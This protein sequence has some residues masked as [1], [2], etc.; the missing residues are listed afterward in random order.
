MRLITIPFSHFCEKARW[1]L[2]R[3]GL[4]FTEE[5]H[6]PMLHWR[7][8]APFGRR[9][10]PLLVTDE[11]VVP[12]S[13]DILRFVDRRL[14]DPKRLY[15]A[16]C[17]AE[18]AA[19][20][21]GFDLGLGPH[22][23][24]LGYYYALPD[25]SSVLKMAAE[26]VPRWE[27]ALLRAS[28]PLARAAMKRGMRIDDEGAA[29]SRA[30]VEKTFAE[31]DARLGDGRR[32]LAGDVLTAADIT[33]AALASPLL[34]PPEHPYAYAFAKATVPAPMSALRSQLQASPAGQLALRVYRDHRRN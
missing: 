28:F 7:A 18:V 16:D 17:E 11:G 19:L 29:R 22:A 5:G 15:P 1:A 13:T 27:A 24:R 8:T 32:Y 6:V 2:E 25:R 31:V 21:D 23:R 9:T 3:A 10:V 26:G 30:L 33:F 4:Q 20:E 14:P 12:D 34:S